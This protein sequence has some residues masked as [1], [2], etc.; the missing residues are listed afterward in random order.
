MIKIGRPE[1]KFLDKKP[2]GLDSIEISI[3]HC[4]EFA[5]AT[6]VAIWI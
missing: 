2:Q 3:S 6:V 1:V 4:K 5:V